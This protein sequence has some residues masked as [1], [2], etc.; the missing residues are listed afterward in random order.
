M[1]FQRILKPAIGADTQV[2]GDEASTF[3]PNSSQPDFVK[4][5]L[6]MILLEVFHIKPKLTQHSGDANAQVVV[7][8]EARRAAFQTQSPPLPRVSLSP[9]TRKLLPGLHSHH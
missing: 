1:P 3:R 4:G 2:S 9:S 7:N 6:G 5:V 8:K